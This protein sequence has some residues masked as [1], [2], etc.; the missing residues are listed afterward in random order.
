MKNEIFL[1]VYN[2]F[3]AFMNVKAMNIFAISNQKVSKYLRVHLLFSL[4][5]AVTGVWPPWQQ[6]DS[7]RLLSS[8]T[9]PL[10]TLSQ[11]ALP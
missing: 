10:S 8:S 1:C 11:G 9:T 3:L 5:L 7:P 4:S 2:L 6:V